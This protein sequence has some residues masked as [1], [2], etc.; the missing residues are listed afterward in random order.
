MGVNNL[1][2]ENALKTIHK[3]LKVSGQGKSHREALTDVFKNIRNEAYK[4]TDGYLVELHV[5]ALFIDKEE[6]TETVKRFLGLILP[7]THEFHQISVTAE[8]EIKIISTGENKL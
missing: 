8:V 3:S 5:T 1:S 6:K 7:V 2:S 4:E